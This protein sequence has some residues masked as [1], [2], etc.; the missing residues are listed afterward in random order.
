[1]AAQAPFSLGSASLGRGHSKKV[2]CH[3]VLFST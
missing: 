3:V 2:S 1:V